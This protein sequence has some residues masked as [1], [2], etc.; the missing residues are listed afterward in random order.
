MFRW[1]RINPTV[2]IKNMLT[3]TSSYSVANI[4]GRRFQVIRAIGCLL[5]LAL[6][7]GCGDGIPRRYPAGGTVKFADGTPVKTGTIEISS[8]TRWTASGE[9][10]REGKF[11]FT[12]VNSG[13]GAIPGEYKAV[14]RQVILS[15]R[16]PAHKHDHGDLVHA[17][18][19]DY[20][21]TTLK[22]TMPAAA[23]LDIEFIVDKAE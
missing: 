18:Y 16:L 1:L 14:I 23:K 13:D 4:S 8:G 19:R 21:S 7:L 17:R 5:L 3:K 11:K 6:V 22:F 15:H 2:L 10:D 12:T 9:I 20:G